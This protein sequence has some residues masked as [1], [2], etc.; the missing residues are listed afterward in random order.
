M[1]KIFHII[2]KKHQVPQFCNINIHFK[3][4][5]CITLLIFA[6]SSFRFRH[7]SNLGCSPTVLITLHIIPFTISQPQPDLGCFLEGN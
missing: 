6:V 3:V 5:L 1:C 2:L 4:Y 7:R